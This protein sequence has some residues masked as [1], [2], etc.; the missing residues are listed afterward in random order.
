MSKNKVLF[1]PA[2]LSILVM[3]RGF[4]QTPPVAPAKVPDLPITRLLNSNRQVN[5]LFSLQGKLTVID[6]FGTWCVPCIKA[7]PHLSALQE[8]YKQELQIILVSEESVAK[9]QAFL[10]K[11]SAFSLPVVVDEQRIFTRFFQPPA[12]PHTIVLDANRNILST[13]TADALT[14]TAIDKWLQ[15]KNAE[16]TSPDTLMTPQSAIISSII[17]KSETVN[18][19]QNKW[20]QLAQSL[21]YAAKTQDSTAEQVAV[22]AQLD[23]DSLRLGLATDE[24]KKAFW[25][26]IY[27]AYTQLLLREDP[28]RYKKRGSFFRSRKIAIAGKWFSLDDIEHGILRRSKIK[29]SLGYLNKWFPGKTERRL[30]VDRLD[31][32]LHFALNCGA[33]SCPPIAFYTAESINAQLDLATKSYLSGEVESNAAGTLIRLPML[34]S[35][36]RRDFGGKKGIRTLLQKQGLIKAGTQPQIQFKK[37]DWSL[38]LQNYSN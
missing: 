8:K 32:R 5:R 38:Y 29:W 25:I 1:F 11:Q 26:N 30:R 22:L 35:W 33:K 19:S 13:G 12:Y 27:N 16:P 31:Y 9:L 37:Y 2:L 18:A 7:L 14:E 21:V 28:A 10:Q 15:T 24:E 36:F 34:M 6:F 3:T 20:V 23:F 17:I 4:G